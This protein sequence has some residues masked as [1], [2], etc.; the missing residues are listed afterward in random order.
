[1]KTNQKIVSF[2]VFLLLIIAGVTQKTY[3][4][5]KNSISNQVASSPTSKLP[6]PPI[7]QSQSTKSSWIKITVPK[8]ENFS[9]TQFT[10]EY[11]DLWKLEGNGEHFAI[12]K[13]QLSISISRPAIGGGVCVF[14]DT[15]TKELEQTPW[16]GAPV[17]TNYSTITTQ[18]GTL[19][20]ALLNNTN[21]N[22]NYEDGS[23]HYQ[24]CELYKGESIYE[25]QTNGGIIS[26]A[27]PAAV[28][29]SELKEIDSILATYEYT[30]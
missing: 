22:V 18:Y 8:L 19:R 17:Y 15:N 4:D 26:I 11:P 13:D 29:K 7:S 9:Y 2:I 24:V 23:N 28:T 10:L 21:P 27:T 12:S 20:R 5:T 25:V 30:K 14:P 3:K 16:Q 1:M 6:I